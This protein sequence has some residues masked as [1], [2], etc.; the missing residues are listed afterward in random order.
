[1]CPELAERAKKKTSS[2]VVKKSVSLDNNFL[3]QMSWPSS[4][5]PFLQQPWLEN[6][7]PPRLLGFLCYR[8]IC[9]QNQLELWEEVGKSWESC[10]SF[11]IPFPSQLLNSSHKYIPISEHSNALSTP[12]GVTWKSIVIEI[13]TSQHLSKKETIWRCHFKGHELQDLIKLTTEMVHLRMPMDFRVLLIVD[14]LSGF[15]PELIH[16]WQSLWV[17]LINDHQ[18]R[19][20]QMAS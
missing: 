2:L 16:L 14:K 1:M 17:L 8:I 18:K 9:H 15:L 3:R 10:E 11:Q 7:V 19:F 12:F 20:K 13:Y 6:L 5:L 4:K